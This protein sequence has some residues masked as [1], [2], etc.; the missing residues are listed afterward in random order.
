MT[1]YKAT[2]E[3]EIIEITISE[4]LEGKRLD[5][6]IGAADI[7]IS[8][9]RAQSLIEDSNVS[10]NGELIT[11][12]KAKLKSGDKLVIDM[13][14]EEPL[15][16]KAEDINIDIV[17][18]D[19]DL[20]VINKPKGMV[21]HPAPGNLT[22]TLVNGLMYHCGDSLSGINGKIRPGIVHRIDKDTSGLLVVA[23]NDEA[24]K[25]LSEQLA[26]HS[27][28]RTYEAIV[29]NNIKDDSGTI[30]APIGRDPA[31]RLRNKVIE[32][33]RKAVTHFEVL[34]RFGKYTY[35]KL[36]LE[37]GR[38][39]QIRVH[40]THIGHPLLGDFVYSN[41]KNSFGVNTQMLHA[42]TLGFIHPRTKR[43]VE[44]TSDLP[45][46]FQNVLRKLKS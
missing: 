36:N 32:G 10:V 25:G 30:D 7:G 42:R 2:G 21:V 18:E 24:H 8:R 23:K 6:A 43:P 13:P 9:N 14:T 5:A 35:I 15:D 29:L 12:K 39:H 46:E 19:D 11:S 44:F 27:M 37:T 17:Y 4:E 38:T 31:N 45:E 22:G 33:G 26:N 16:V 1:L 3:S 20:I 41:A 28:E 40:M 34:E